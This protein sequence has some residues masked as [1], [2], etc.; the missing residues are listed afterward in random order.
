[1]TNNFSSSNGF[2]KATMA[3]GTSPKQVRF[4]SKYRLEVAQAAGKVLNINKIFLS[5]LNII[6]DN[7]R[8]LQIKDTLGKGVTLK[9]FTYDQTQFNGAFGLIMKDGPKAKVI[10]GFELNSVLTFQSIRA[11]TQKACIKANV[12]T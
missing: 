5:I 7:D 9:L 11:M 4:V 8:S 10:L 2:T 12:T 6:A 3:K 1:M